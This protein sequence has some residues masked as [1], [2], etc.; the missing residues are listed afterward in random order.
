MGY[1]R[2]SHRNPRDIQSEVC[3]LCGTLIG[4]QHLFTADCE[5][6]RGRTICDRHP[7]GLLAPSILDLRAHSILPT[8][9]SSRREPIGG[10]F[11]WAATSLLVREDGSY[12]LREEAPL[13]FI[14]REA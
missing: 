7:P 2:P 5:V 6:L 11:W 14:A 12:F 1:R 4:H 10:S 13:A 8:P 9:D 3:E